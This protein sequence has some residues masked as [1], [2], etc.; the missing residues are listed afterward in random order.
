MDHN[1]H[2]CKTSLL[3]YVLG[4]FGNVVMMGA[5]TY[6]LYYNLVGYI[7]LYMFYMCC[8]YGMYMTTSIEIKANIF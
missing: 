2:V 3:G 4:V 1:A 5:F 6:N 8:N 7:V